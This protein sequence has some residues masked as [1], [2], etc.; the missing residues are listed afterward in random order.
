MINITISVNDD[1]GDLSVSMQKA[2]VFML[3][4]HLRSKSALFVEKGC[5]IRVAHPERPCMDYD[6]LTSTVFGSSR[7]LD[8]MVK[9][10]LVEIEV[11]KIAAFAQLT[12][13]G[14]GFGVDLM[15]A[16][17]HALN[18]ADQCVKKAS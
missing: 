13:K 3:T 6:D 16:V 8:A 7:V 5:R 15:S 17:H 10:E 4:R 18:H 14:F 9:R 2:L 11:G 12:T 1:F